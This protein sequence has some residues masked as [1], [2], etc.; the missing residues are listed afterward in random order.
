MLTEKEVREWRTHPTTE[1]V[2]DELVSQVSE[3][4]EDI[5]HGGTINFESAQETALKTIFKL[6]VIEGIN[7][8]IQV[9]GDEDGE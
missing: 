8:V 9:Q 1:K 2:L 4:N 5:L 6:G 3:L 7:R